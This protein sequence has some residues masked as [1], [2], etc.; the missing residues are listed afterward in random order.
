ML[1]TNKKRLRCLEKCGN[2]NLSVFPSLALGGKIKWQ[3]ENTMKRRILSLT[4]ALLMALSVM[5]FPAA[6]YEKETIVPL[7]TE[8][9]CPKHNVMERVTSRRYEH[10]IPVDFCNRRDDRHIHWER[11]L[12]YEYE[13]GYIHSTVLLYQCL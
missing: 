8:S 12:E 13:C 11:I 7:A 9:T 1:K 5:A 3:E 2:I 10:N 4:L 6:A